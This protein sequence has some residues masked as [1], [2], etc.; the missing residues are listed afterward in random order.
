MSDA[1]CELPER[2]ASSEEIRRL[3]TSARTIAIVGL[4]GNPARDSHRVAAYLQE[5]GY[6]VIPV[7]PALE[8][9]LGEKSYPDLASVPVPIDIVDVFR[10]PQAIPGIVDDAIAAKAKAVWM[11][12]GLA[13]NAAAAKARAAGLAVVMSKCIMAQ[14]RGLLGG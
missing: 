14:H 10:K 2:N 4:S 7:N 8:E 6:R 3:L 11:Q 1:I 9:V 12:L 13:D 5:H